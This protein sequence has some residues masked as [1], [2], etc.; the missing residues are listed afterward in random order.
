MDLDILRKRFAPFIMLMIWV[1]VAP[2]AV[3]SATVGPGIFTWPVALA[4]AGALTATA[5]L[6]SRPLAPA[7]RIASAFA[8][9]AIGAALTA[10]LQHQ[11]TQADASMI[12]IAI[13]ALLSGWCDRRVS[14][15]GAGLIVAWHIFAY[16]VQPSWVM[17]GDPSLTRLAARIVVAALAVEGVGWILNNLHN[18]AERVDEALTEAFSAKRE[19]EKLAGERE[20]MAKANE[21]ERKRRMTEVADAFKAR[22]EGVILAVLKGAQAMSG[23]AQSLAEI[24]QTT[25]SLAASASQASSSSDH[26]VRSVAAASDHIAEALNRM[27]RQIEETSLAVREAAE[28]ANASARQVAELSEAAEQIGAVVSLIQSIAQKTNLLALNATIESARAGE[29]GKGFA[30]VAS[31][32]KGLAEQTQ[33]ATEEVAEHIANIRNATTETVDIIQAISSAMNVVDEHAAA[34]AEAMEEQN[35]ATEEISRGARGAAEATGEVARSVGGVEGSAQDA[36][37]AAEIVRSESE[38][39]DAQAQKLRAEVDRFMADI[40]A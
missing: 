18:A 25:L 14:A 16:I 35:R 23:S 37:K 19:T 31:E 27:S 29:A 12:F 17:A 39:L 10:A 5:F 3:L 24:A 11:P 28:R 15:T 4:L 21:E 26:E 6:A 7:S 1:G 13:I 34:I 20:L 9:V 36:R 22:V 38:Q 2:V 30:V 40:A 32:V 33:R 8:L